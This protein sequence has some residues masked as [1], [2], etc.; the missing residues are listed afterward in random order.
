M[1]QLI[2]GISDKFITTL[3]YNGSGQIIYQGYATPN[4]SKDK[5]VWQIRKLTYNGMNL[6]DVQFAQGSKEFNFIWNNRAG[7]TYS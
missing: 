2:E 6:T 4:S 7:Y 1:S 5:A 3:D